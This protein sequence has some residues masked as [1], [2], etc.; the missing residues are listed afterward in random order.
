MIQLKELCIVCELPSI[1][2]K[3]SISGR[4]HNTKEYAIEWADGYKL[5]FVNGVYIN[6]DLFEKFR[7]NQLDFKELIQIKNIEQRYSLM[8]EYNKEEL[9]KSAELELVD[10]S[11]LGNELYISKKII[12]GKD[13]KI[14]TYL[15][16][17]TKRRY[18]K[19]VPYEMK[20]ADESNAWC[21]HM[22]KKQYLTM[23]KQS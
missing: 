15:C 23:N 13:V 1:I 9:F 11:E 14:L 22:T 17:S 21:H 8:K 18:Y 10:K 2:H 20:D 16:P 19:F 3:E 4:L 5:A 6:Y 12:E 7:N